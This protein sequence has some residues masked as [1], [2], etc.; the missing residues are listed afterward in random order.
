M[1][2][3]AINDPQRLLDH[4]LACGWTRREILERTGIAEARLDGIFQGVLVA[5]LE[6]LA[7]LHSLVG[8]K[9][10]MIEHRGPTP[11]LPARNEMH[12]Q[13]MRWKLRFLVY[14]NWEF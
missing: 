4:L 7:G 5:D 2:R 14:E 12:Q 13:G 1:R 8:K 9:V 11:K 3:R 10:P 6:E